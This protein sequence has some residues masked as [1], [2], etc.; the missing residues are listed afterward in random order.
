MTRADLEQALEH[1]AAAEARAQPGSAVWG[2]LRAGRGDALLH[3]VFERGGDEDY[4]AAV[5]AYRDAL[6]ALPPDDRA[7]GN[8]VASLGRALHLRYRAR[9]RDRADLDEAC[10]LFASVHGEPIDVYVAEA[11]ADRFE[12]DGDAADEEA[13]AARFAAA[14]DTP[15][16]GARIPAAASWG[17]WAAHRGAWAEARQAYAHGVS[18]LQE[19]YEAQGSATGRE[20]WLQTAQDAPPRRR[21]RV[22]SRG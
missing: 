5:T 16:A 10:R 11:L 6:D 7:H 9:S 17:L 12:L 13:V 15:A 21:V 22:G 3:R 1:L 19:L 2:R 20:L 18:A 4:T 14:I 8:V